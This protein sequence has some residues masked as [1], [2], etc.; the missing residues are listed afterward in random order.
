MLKINEH[1]FEKPAMSTKQQFYNFL[2]LFMRQCGDALLYTHFIKVINLLT[3]S[4]QMSGTFSWHH[5]LLN[6]NYL[7]ESFS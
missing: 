4:D 1:K 3:S 5:F 2:V 6:K 7:T